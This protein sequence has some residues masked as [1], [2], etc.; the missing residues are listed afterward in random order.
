MKSTSRCGWSKSRGV[1]VDGQS[2]AR[3]K[4]L[5]EGDASCCPHGCR[6]TWYLPLPLPCW[7]T[8][9]LLVQ[10]KREGLESDPLVRASRLWRE[11]N[12]GGRGCVAGVPSASSGARRGELDQVARRPWCSVEA[13]GA[14]ACWMRRLAGF[15]WSSSQGRPREAAFDGERS[16]WLRAPGLSADVYP[17]VARQWGDGGA[18]RRSGP[19]CGQGEL[20]RPSDGNQARDGAPHRLYLR[21]SHLASPSPQLSAGRGKA[22]SVLWCCSW[23]TASPAFPAH[24]EAFASAWELA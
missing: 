8:H 4:D 21:G 13:G 15:P 6:A 3:E 12:A 1:D 14:S 10:D 22:E 24:V 18:S 5:V 16:G 9:S 19:R 23:Q 11:S 7:S 17:G 2:V 20:P